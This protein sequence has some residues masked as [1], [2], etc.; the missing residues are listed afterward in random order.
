MLPVYAAE[1][2]TGD[3]TGDQHRECC[4]CLLQPHHRGQHRGEHR[5]CGLCLLKSHHRGESREC[6]LCLLTG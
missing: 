6:C 4:L 5:E 2:T 3:N 1:P